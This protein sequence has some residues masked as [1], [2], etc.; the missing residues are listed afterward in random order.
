VLRQADGRV[1]TGHDD[2][3]LPAMTID[4]ARRPSTG[5]VYRLNR[6]LRSAQLFIVSNARLS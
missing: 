2:L 5:L 6:D 4:L 1:K 3:A